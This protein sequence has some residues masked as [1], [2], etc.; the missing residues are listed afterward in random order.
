M[1]PPQ[2]STVTVHRHGDGTESE[3]EAPFLFLALECSRPQALSARATL[4]G[5]DE[6][7][8]GRGQVRSAEREMVG[9]RCVLRVRVPDPSMSQTHARLERGLGEWSVADAQSKNGTLVN[10]VPTERTRLHDGDLITLGYTVFLFRSALTV[11]GELPPWVDASTSE[12]VEPGLATLVPA[13]ERDFAR[14]VRIAP[15]DVTVMIRG[16]TGTGKELLT[17]ALHRLSGRSGQMVAINCGALTDTLIESELFGHKKGSFSGAIDDSMGLVRAADR[18]TLLL[19]EIGDLPAQSQAAFLRV[20]QEREVVPVGST[21]GVAVDIRVVSATHRDLEALAHGGSFRADLL[22]R[23]SGMRIDLPRLTDR[24]EDLGL[25]I[26]IIVS[27]MAAPPSGLT[28]AAVRAL[29]R[30]SWPHNIRELDK[31]L[32]AAAVLAAG[33]PLDIHHLGNAIAE[34][35]AQIAAP[36]DDEELRARLASLLERHQG[37]ISAVAR[38][39][40]KA[41]MQ[42]H[43]WMQRFELDPNSFR[44]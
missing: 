16:E 32:G 14:L 43:R 39:M 38:D 42:I 20:L 19:D 2:D 15:S 1:S 5:V 27:R 33:Q 24:L 37:N 18:G 3:R 26:G 36:R 13:L 29:Y 22:A 30:Y 11:V 44:R 31:V 8:I 12:I 6:V 41:R 9:G 34:G 35:Q 17:R 25:L 21:R 28:E 23:V 4:E 7:V 40:G 10:G